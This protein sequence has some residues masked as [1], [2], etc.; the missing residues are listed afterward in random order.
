MADRLW[1]WAALAGV[2]IACAKGAHDWFGIGRYL[3]LW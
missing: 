1:G 2:G 3:G